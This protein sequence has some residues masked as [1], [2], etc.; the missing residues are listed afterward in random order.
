MPDH[1][2][3]VLAA[4][5]VAALAFAGYWRHLAQRRR[6]LTDGRRRGGRK[7]A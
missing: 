6:A 4:Y 7:A 3:Y 2:G 5:G 1:W